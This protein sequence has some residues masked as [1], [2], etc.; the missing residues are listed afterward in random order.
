M[1]ELY[2]AANRKTASAQLWGPGGGCGDV[3]AKKNPKNSPTNQKIPPPHLGKLTPPLGE[4]LRLVVHGEE[5]E[6]EEQGGPGG[7]PPRHPARLDAVH[8]S[9]TH[10][11]PLWSTHM[12]IYIN[13]N[14][15]EHRAF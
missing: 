5:E 11:G 2:T 15:I 14:T 7:P 8:A 1:C 6:G 4:A 9:V 13:N 12:T 3:A 10:G